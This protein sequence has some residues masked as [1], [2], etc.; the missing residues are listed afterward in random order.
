MKGPDHIASLEPKELSKLV[1]SI[2][3][4]EL[5]LG[6]NKKFATKSEKKNIKIVRKSIVAKKK[7]LKGEKFTS[8][9][10]YNKKTW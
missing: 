1:K 6:K 8:S 10:Y 2:R 3:N 5:A 4:I 7:I 9:K